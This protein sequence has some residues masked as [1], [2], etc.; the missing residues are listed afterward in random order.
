MLPDARIIAWHGRSAV[1]SQRHE[2]MWP[3]GSA[4]WLHP[5]QQ[6]GFEAPLLR[7]L[8]VDGTWGVIDLARA[9]P[10]LAADIRC[11]HRRDARGLV[12]FTLRCGFAGAQ[13]FVAQMRAY[14]QPAEEVAA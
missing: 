4:V 10:D 8:Q 2:I 14:L 12:F 13:A 1:L 9:L 3:D 7:A 11:H 6:D 5:V